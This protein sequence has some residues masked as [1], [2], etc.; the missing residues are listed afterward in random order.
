M[1]IYLVPSEPPTNMEAL[2]LNSSAVYVKW[3]APRLESRNGVLK[4]YIVIVRGVNIYENI[5]KVLT[6]I[7]I[8][9]STS[10]LM[11]ANLT[12]GVTYT[13]SVAAV[14]RA[15]LG[16]FSK[17]AMLRLDPITKQLDTTYNQRYPIN[18]DHMDDFLTQ[19]WFIVLLGVILLI[20]MLSFAIM[21]FIKRKHITMKQSRLAAIGGNYLNTLNSIELIQ[22]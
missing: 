6:N 1:F 15:G 4:T 12:E 18:S 17:P 7:T 16:P 19:T 2:L 13:V 3:K 8:N 22:N 10:S 9:A 11:L 14:N 21:V 5:S 20:I